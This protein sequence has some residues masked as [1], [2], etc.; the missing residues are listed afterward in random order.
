MKRLVVVAAV[1]V[2]LAGCGPK[3]GSTA[4]P[5]SFIPNCVVGLRLMGEKDASWLGAKASPVAPDVI[6]RSS[7]QLVACAAEKASGQVEAYRVRVRCVGSIEM[8]CTS[9]A[10]AVSEA[11][12]DGA[13]R[14]EVGDFNSFTFAQH[15][16]EA[17]WVAGE[18]GKVDPNRSALAF[19]WDIQGEKQ[20]DGTTNIRCAA[21]SRDKPVTLVA[22]VVCSDP[23]QDRCTQLVSVENP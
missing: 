19:P 5:S 12:V 18:R 7:P 6:D 4:S 8:H 9:L 2:L 23:E 15:C 21:E 13:R 20:P 10:D 17:L 22:R 3:D 11:R 14:A 1:G 16:S